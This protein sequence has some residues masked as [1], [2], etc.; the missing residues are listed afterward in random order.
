MALFLGLFTPKRLMEQTSSQ[1]LHPEQRSGTTASFQD[2]FFSLPYVSSPSVG[3][4]GDDHSAFSNFLKAL[5][6]ISISSLVTSRWVTSRIWV[7]PM[8]WMRAPSFFIGSATWEAVIPL[9]ATSKM[10][11]VV[12]TNLGSM[13]TPLSSF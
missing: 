10:T 9:L 3:E 2:I 4:G 8:G 1:I 13:E 5:S 6:A 7:L 12:S 11:I